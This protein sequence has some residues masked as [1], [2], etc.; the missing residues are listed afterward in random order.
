MVIGLADIR[1]VR[2]EE[3]DHLALH[4]AL[5]G[6][7]ALMQ[8]VVAVG[9][10]GTRVPVDAD[11]EPFLAHDADVAIVHLDILANENLRHSS[12]APGFRFRWAHL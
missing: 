6:G 11:L 2:S 9:I 8:A 7:A 5:A 10:V 1:L 4:H 12:P 3:F